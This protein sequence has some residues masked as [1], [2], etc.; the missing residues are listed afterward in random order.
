MNFNS[1]GFT[2]FNLPLLRELNP[3][4]V[5]GDNTSLIGLIVIVA[6]IIGVIAIGGRAQGGK[7]SKRSKN[8][9]KFKK[10]TFRKQAAAMGL[11][12]VQ[13]NTLENLMERYRVPNPYLLFTHP[14]NLDQLL[15]HGMNDIETQVSSDKI[16]DSQKLTLFRIKQKVERNSNKAGSVK[17]TKQLQPGQKIV[18][19]PQ[20]GGKYPV[21]VLTN[22][23]DAIGVQIP[24]SPTGQVRL[25]KGI[26]VKVFFWKNNGQGFSFMSK[27]LGYTKIRGNTA[28]LL[29]HTNMVKEAQQRRFR[30][31]EL[32]R[33][34]YCYPVRVITTG[35]GKAKKKKAFVESKNGSLGT[36]LEVSSGGCS[37]KTTYPLKRGELIKI[38]FE[39]YKGNPVSGYGKVVSMTKVRPMGGIMHVQFTRLSQKFMNR[40][41]SFV[42]EM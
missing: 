31:K 34:T 21:K 7:S 12:K 13:L 29:K 19:N 5:Q 27:I 37:I 18:I 32:N 28:L 26:P 4:V 35:V 24:D 23:K 3:M 15:Q 33:P 2:S 10:S 9:G 25:N 20:T 1:F 38:D 8:S 22:L 42:Y 17:A 11:N 39:T 30:R 36:I 40:I 16:K 6:I 14:K 41:N